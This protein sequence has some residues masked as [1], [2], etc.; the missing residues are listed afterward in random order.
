LNFA[1]FSKDFFSFLR[2][3]NLPNDEIRRYTVL[4]HL[5]YLCLLLDQFLN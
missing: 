5:S 2:L 1:T 4:S 3:M